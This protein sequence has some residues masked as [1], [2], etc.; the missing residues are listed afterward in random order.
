MTA[1]A[2][3]Q[4][5]PAPATQPPAANQDDNSEEIVVLAQPGDQVR[6]DR[7]TYT[8]RDDPAAQSTNMYD[9]LGQIPS[10]SVAPSGA[11]TLLGASDVTIQIDG[12]PVP[13]NNLEQ[14]LRGLNGS[15]VERIEVGRKT[16]GK[17]VRILVDANQ[18]YNRVEAIRR[19]RA[20]Q[21]LGCF[22]Y[23]EPL[24][25]WD[26]EGYGELAQTLD[27]RIATGEEPEDFGRE[28]EKNKAAQELGRKGGKKGG[29]ARA[30]KRRRRIPERPMTSLLGV[31]LIGPASV[32]S[33]IRPN[34]SMNSSFRDRRRCNTGPTFGVAM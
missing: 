11:V 26:H 6:I 34:L 17:D 23:E 32:F 21:E 12:R 27:M 7:R 13:G 4:E 15:D 9:V 2:Y 30:A 18:A 33:S 19:G 8:L 16:A 3:A 22:W 1:S 14:V 31:G 29:L 20:Y 28:E 10:V 5:A 25:P 24:P